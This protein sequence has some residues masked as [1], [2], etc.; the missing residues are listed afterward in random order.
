MLN[1]KDLVNFFYLFHQIKI[2]K[3]MILKIMIVKYQTIFLNLKTVNIPII[4]LIFGISIL[5]KNF[6]N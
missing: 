2:L 4:F 5:I 1:K 3:D 6:S